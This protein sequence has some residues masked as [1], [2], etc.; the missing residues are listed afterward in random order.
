[1]D[2]YLRKRL[3]R[4]IHP[5]ITA[6]RDEGEATSTFLKPPDNAPQATSSNAVTVGLQGDPA[7]TLVGSD[8]EDED[9]DVSLYDIATLLALCWSDIQQ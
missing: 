5:A 6:V 1:L 9:Y 2:T 8:G 7:P 3:R 4:D